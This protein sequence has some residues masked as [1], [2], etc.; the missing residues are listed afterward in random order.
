MAAT[1]TARGLRCLCL[2]VFTMAS[3]LQ[4]LVGHRET[5]GGGF[6]PCFT[7]K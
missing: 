5:G 4:P 1:T 3:E 6:G 7:P 2:N